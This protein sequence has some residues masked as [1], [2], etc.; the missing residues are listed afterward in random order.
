MADSLK[1]KESAIHLL[2]NNAG[3]A[4]EE[5]MKFGNNDKL[6]FNSAE[7]VSEHLLRDTDEAWADTFKTNATAVF[8]T[9]AHLLPLLAK[10]CESFHG[11]TSSIV[12]IASISGL[13]KVCFACLGQPYTIF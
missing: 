4:V 1:Q 2:V 9:S 11:Y 10:G 5:Q 8:F 13:M 12:N 7:S 3:I 6:D